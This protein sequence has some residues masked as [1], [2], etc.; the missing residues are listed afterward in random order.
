MKI[1]SELLFRTFVDGNVNL[2]HESTRTVRDVHRIDNK[3]ND[4]VEIGQ[5]CFFEIS[6]DNDGYVCIFAVN[7][8]N[9][10]VSD[11]FLKTRETI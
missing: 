6:L 5:G 3:G 1:K 7:H 4:S 2:S 8:I 11:N 10:F 9:C